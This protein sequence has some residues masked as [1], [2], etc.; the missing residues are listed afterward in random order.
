M[1]KSTAFL[2]E[3]QAGPSTIN[4]PADVAASRPA[5]WPPALSEEQRRWGMRRLQLAVRAVRRRWGPGGG[6]RLASLLKIVAERV[7][8]TK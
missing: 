2:A 3:V 1:E 6:P 5:D 7:E 8:G 4:T